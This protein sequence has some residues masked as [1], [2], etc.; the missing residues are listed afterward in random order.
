VICSQ[1]VLPLALD[2][3]SNCKAAVV[4]ILDRGP[5]RVLSAGPAEPRFFNKVVTPPPHPFPT[6]LGTGLG[7]IRA[8]DSFHGFKNTKINVLLWIM[9]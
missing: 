1:G 5:H 2:E 4:C 3:P 8:S 9:H 6:W 7:V